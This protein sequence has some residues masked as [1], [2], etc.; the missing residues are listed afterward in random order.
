MMKMFIDYTQESVVLVMLYCSLI[1]GGYSVFGQENFEALIQPKIAINLNSDKLFSQNF[2]FSLRSF[3]YKND[4]RYRG[5]H[6]QASHFS[7]LAVSPYSKLSVGIMYRNLNLFD[8]NI[9][10]EIRTTQQYNYAKR[11]NSVRFGHRIRFEERIRRQRFAFRARY[12]FAADFPL[13][14]QNLDT[15]EFYGLSNVEAVSSFQRNRTGQYESRLTLGVGKVLKE[16]IKTQIMLH[17]RLL[18]V[19]SSRENQLFFLLETHIKI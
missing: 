3:V 9:V 8:G 5:Q 4:W 13:Q 7:T 19:F 1:N 14:G 6:V 10:N 17:Y 11:I 12:R 16:N 18:D 2:S 15:G